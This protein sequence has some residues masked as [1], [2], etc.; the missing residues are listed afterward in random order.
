MRGYFEALNE[1]GLWMVVPFEE[2]AYQLDA[3]YIRD[4]ADVFSVEGEVSEWMLSGKFNLGEQ[5]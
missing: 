2:P 3:R 5:S 4:P 1:V